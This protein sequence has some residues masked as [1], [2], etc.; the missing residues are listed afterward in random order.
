MSDHLGQEGLVS[1]KHPRYGLYQ[2]RYLTSLPTLEFSKILSFD[3][4][5]V[6]FC[7]VLVC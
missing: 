1:R 4:I 7:E 5:V 6:P 2:S 3:V